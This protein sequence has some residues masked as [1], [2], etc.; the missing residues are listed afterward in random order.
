[1]RLVD[2]YQ[3]VLL[4]AHEPPC[5]SLYQP[6]SRHHPDNQQDP[7]R[8][9]NLVRLLEQSL[10][11]LDSVQVGQPLLTRFNELGEDSQ[12]WN[13]SL[14]GLAVLAAPDVF[15]IYRLQRPVPELAI[16]AD[17]FHIKPLL[18][19][20]QSADRYQILALTASEITLFE[21]NRDS[22]AAVDLADGVPQ[23]LTE[24]L[25]D[26]LTEPHQTVA[27]YGMGAGDGKGGGGTPMKQGHGGRKDELEI[28]ADKFFRAVDRA[29]LEHHSRP[30]GLPL[31]LAALPEHG[32]RFRS[33][34]HNP[35]LLA[36][37]VDGS[38]DALAIDA[39]C[40]R[41]WQVVEP[42]Y[43]ARLAGL[44]D[45]FGA[46]SSNDRGSDEVSQVAKAAVAGR[47]ATLLIDADCR[48]PGHLDRTSGAIEIA[49]LADAEIDDL[50]DDLAE[51][52]LRAGG[53]VVVV[54]PERMPAT[55]G[56]AAIYR[57]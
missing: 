8:F 16:V 45:D 2:D 24:A 25:G 11:R 53:E 21:G 50:L 5:L 48:V 15:R 14:E 42:Q 37:G 3:S 1:M 33:V 4:A 46:A 36:D 26:E 19:I 39:L 43:I 52:V 13:H 20:L 55:T 35:F 51:V 10:H 49:D 57:Y 7:I 54:P 56:L 40:D 23:T 29:I 6:T 28:D 32:S 18:R 47:V 38:P 44:V 31:L 41:A 30:S 12:F 34:S 17:S 22:L 27:S 9:R